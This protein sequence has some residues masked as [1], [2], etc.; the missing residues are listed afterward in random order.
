[1]LTDCH[2]GR[3]QAHR[4][5][6]TSTPGFWFEG[7]RPDERALPL[8]ARLERY[9]D[10]EASVLAFAT[11]EHSLELFFTFLPWVFQSL[12]VAFGVGFVLLALSGIFSE[13]GATVFIVGGGYLVSGV[14]LPFFTRTARQFVAAVQ[15]WLVPTFLIWLVGCFVDGWASGD[16]FFFCFWTPLFTAIVLV[17]AFRPGWYLRAFTLVFLLGCVALPPL[18]CIVSWG[19]TS[20]YGECVA[21][22]YQ[23]W[24]PVAG[25]LGA[26]LLGALAQ[27]WAKHTMASRALKASR[28]L[29]RL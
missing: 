6:L 12:C 14:F 8:S 20:S 18:R 17:L 4:K 9:R 27:M 23:I 19:T 28:G 11:S 26:Q 15:W 10:A 7:A 29:H 1:L 25:V 3:A 13:D 24:G 5:L 21:T 2:T 22:G 16:F